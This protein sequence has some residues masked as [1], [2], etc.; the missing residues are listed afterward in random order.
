MTKLESEEITKAK[1]INV[2]ET[3]IFLKLYATKICCFFLNNFDLLPCPGIKFSCITSI[4]PESEICSPPQIV[5]IWISDFNVSE[6][7]CIVYFCFA[8]SL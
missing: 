8:P 3:V 5:C 7:T 4:L 6:R 2:I 1:T